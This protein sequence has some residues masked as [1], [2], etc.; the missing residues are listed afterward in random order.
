MKIKN[1]ILLIYSNYIR[2]FLLNSIRYKIIAKIKI[3]FRNTTINYSII[4]LI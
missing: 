1:T 3:L 2:T 4:L